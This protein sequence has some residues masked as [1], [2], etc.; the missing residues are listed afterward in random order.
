M[1][2]V[3]ICGC[4]DVDQSVSISL[5][6]KVT[7]AEWLSVV[8]GQS[9]RDEVEPKRKKMDQVRPAMDTFFM[10]P[11]FSCC[12]NTLLMTIVLH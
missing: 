2:V 9:L 7:A 11:T 1:W 12:F 4:K 5:E 8:G 6:S 10:L 3:T